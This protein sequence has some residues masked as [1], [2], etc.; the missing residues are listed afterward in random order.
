MWEGAAE[1]PVEV[2]YLMTD[3]EYNVDLSVVVPCYNEANRFPP[4]FTETYEASLGLLCVVVS[5]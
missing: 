5:R 3:E 4:N 1:V 2:P